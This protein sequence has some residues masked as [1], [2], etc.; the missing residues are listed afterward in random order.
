[1]RCKLLQS[2]NN[3]LF[4][5]AGFARYPDRMALWRQVSG[6]EEQLA[7]RRVVEKAV[8]ILIEKHGLGYQAPRNES[9]GSPLIMELRSLLPS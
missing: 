3:A 9:R 8:S 1:M 7:T 4:T 5:L 6:L 2:A